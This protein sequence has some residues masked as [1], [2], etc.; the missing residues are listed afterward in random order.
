MSALP[1]L[2]LRADA[3]GLLGS[4]HVMRSLALGEAWV[5]AGGA[6]ILASVSLPQT[7]EARVSEGRGFLVRR[8]AA[9]AWSKADAAAVSALAK[10]FSARAVVA[11]SYLY[12]AGYL[13]ALKDQGVCVT[14]ID[15]LARLATYPCNVLVNPNLAGEEALY[16]GKAENVRRLLGPRYV[17][18]RREFSRHRASV[19]SI[20][21]VAHKLLVTFGGVDPKDGGGLALQAL[22]MTPNLDVD[23]VIGAANARADDLAAKAAALPNVRIIRDARDMA[24]R[25][26]E[27]EMILSAGGTTVWEA[28]ALGAPMMLAAAAPE[29]ANAAVRLAK[30]GLALFL[31]EIE[32]LT[33]NALG[34]ALN[35]FAGD[36]AARARSSVLGRELV[37]GFGAE[38]VV[39]AIRAFL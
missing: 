9:E 38:R 34:A 37:D 25:I 33:P 21:T 29:E 36:M 32:A 27:C 18:L 19:R 8:I 7:L 16:A 26:M 35:D 39:E 24:A 14:A 15:D 20:A 31:G 5:D 2:L 23:F 22:A 6:C 4:G 10:Q 3:G 17:M 12:N 30:G 13:A 28:A 1:P 11:D